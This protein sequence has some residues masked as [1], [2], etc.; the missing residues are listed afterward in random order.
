MLVKDLLGVWVYAINGLKLV[1][2]RVTTSTPVSIVNVYELYI[3]RR[4]M[5]ACSILLDLGPTLS[6]EMR[7]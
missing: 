2:E 5:H 7:T 3:C 6:Y 4:I 1:I